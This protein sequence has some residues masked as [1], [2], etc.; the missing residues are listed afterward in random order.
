MAAFLGW[1][2]AFRRGR[3]CLISDAVKSAGVATNPIGQIESTLSDG[4]HIEEQRLNELF[5]LWS[6]SENAIAGSKSR[7]RLASENDAIR[8]NFLIQKDSLSTTNLNQSDQCG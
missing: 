1:I 4:Q 8:Q 5:K 2:R 7:A 6:I 3:N